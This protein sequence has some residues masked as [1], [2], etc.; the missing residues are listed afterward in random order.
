[1]L[2]LERNFRSRSGEI[3]IIAEDGDY[4]VFVEV[5][6]RRNSDKG[7]PLAAVGM[8]KQKKI[9]R[10]ADYYRYIRRVSGNQKLRYD[11]VAILDDSVYHIKNAF[12]H[13]SANGSSW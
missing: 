7:G 1:M 2:I 8:Q 12:Y 3:D 11:V 5:K 13:T 9:C 6:Y 4:L 10:V